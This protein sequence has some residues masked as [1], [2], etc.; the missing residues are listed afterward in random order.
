MPDFFNQATL[1]YNNQTTLSNIVTGQLVEV[2]SAAKTALSPSY[3][4]GD[5]VTYA[6]SIVNAGSTAYT[7][8]TVTDDLGAYP[9]GGGT[10]TPLDYVEGSVTLFVN[11]VLQPAPTVTNQQPLTITGINVP[12]DSNA[13][14]IYSAQ[15][16]QF[17]PLS[18]GA[19][20]NNTATISGGGVTTPITAGATIPADEEPSLSII[21]AINPVNVVENEP[22]TYTFTIQNTST[23]PAVATDNVTITDVFDPIIDIQ[24]VTLNGVPLAQGTGY[25]YNETTGF[26]ATVPSVIT[27]PA[28]TVQQ[29]PI[30]G[31]WTVLP[32][33]AVVTVTGII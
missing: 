13:V 23:T 9:F 20:I 30:T 8:L 6:I 24:S 4:T 26:F 17:A 11:G 3:R 25:T 21:K 1:I 32:G 10:L 7:G 16:N 12:A 14:L 29:D 18:A 28:A 31:A 33:T 22:F 19:E 5:T 27:V 15:V 2:L